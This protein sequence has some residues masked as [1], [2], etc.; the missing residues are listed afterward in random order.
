MHPTRLASLCGGG[1]CAN[2]RGR[3]SPPLHACKLSTR[4]RPSSHARGAEPTH[5]LARTPSASMRAPHTGKGRGATRPH[6][7]PPH[8]TPRPAVSLPAPARACSPG[9]PRACWPSARTTAPKEEGGR[10]RGGRA[11]RGGP[12]QLQ[13]WQQPRQLCQAAARPSGCMR[14]RRLLPP[15]RLRGPQLEG[16]RRRRRRRRG[17]APRCTACPRRAR[18]GPHRPA[19]CGRHRE[20][21]PRP[22]GAGRRGRRW[23]TCLAAMQGGR[24]AGSRSALCCRFRGSQ[25]VAAAV[26]ARL[27]AAA[28]A[29]LALQNWKA[30]K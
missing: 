30:S 10:W 6:P 20:G 15:G 23:R 1:A 12:K 2:R 4:T 27:P 22:R 26:A 11:S 9:T 13:G 19:G 25:P 14:R 8:P 28:R 18:L 21:S 29:R 5:H 17:G 3:G 16:R 7:Q 24:A